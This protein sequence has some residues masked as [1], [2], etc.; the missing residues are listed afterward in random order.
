MW[1]EY[2][3]IKM[4]YQFFKIGLFVFFKGHQTV[5]DQSCVFEPISQCIRK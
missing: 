3:L 1:I 4:E 2:I 5:Q